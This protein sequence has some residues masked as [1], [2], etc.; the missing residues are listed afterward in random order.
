MEVLGERLDC[1]QWV[2]LSILT[3]V[4]VIG[5]LS[6][7]LLGIVTRPMSQ[8]IH[9]GDRACLPNPSL[10]TSTDCHEATN[11]TECSNMNLDGA[12][13]T[14]AFTEISPSHCIWDYSGL[15]LEY[16]IL[17]GPAF[18]AVFT[19]TGILLGIAADRVNR[20]LLV[21]S[22]CLLLSVATGL[23]G[24]ATSFWHLVVLRMLIG[25]G[26][27]SFSPACSSLISDIFPKRLHAMALG[28]FNWGI[29]FGYGLS[30][31]VGNYI[32]A[33]NILGMGW[34]WAFIFS[35]IFG[36]LVALALLFF[37]KEP[38]R[39]N[40]D[41]RNLS[42]SQSTKYNVDNENVQM[43]IV[44]SATKE[45]DEKVEEVAEV[46][47]NGVEEENVWPFGKQLGMIDI[48]KSFL[49]PGVIILFIAASARHTAGFCWAY[50]TQLYFTTYF[51]D[52]DLGLWVTV[53]SIV[54][55][56]LGV[57]V[58]GLVSDKLVIHLGLP[59]R[60]YVLAGSQLLAT[61]LAAGVLY[62]PPPQAFYCLF[63]A[64]LFAEMWFGVLFAVLIEVFP[65]QLKSTSIAIFLFIMNNIG[66]NIPVLVDPLS[67]HFTYRDALY[68]MYP[69][70]Y[71]TSSILF[72][73]ASFIIRA[74]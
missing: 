74:T 56:S 62:F 23:M 65:P 8:D 5:E 32:T 34:R 17:A 20:K 39:T 38:C 51:P 1:T 68:L 15:G 18:I 60:L 19:T 49:R 14:D 26:E 16:Q 41:R 43:D 45:T 55:G 11:V 57:A 28:I 33:A 31:V 52:F 27:S 54:G 4:Y 58:G 35:G 21:T 40:S 59:S 67:K 36:I 70:M 22:C 24:A 29:Y 13:L 69:G 64:Y 72:F 9:Y 47:K 63:A 44:E 42:D 12:S 71:L 66:G 53:V 25:A 73:L 48:L 30:Y 2:H 46:M 3:M 61:P 50:N 10:S 37:V 6:H 7:F